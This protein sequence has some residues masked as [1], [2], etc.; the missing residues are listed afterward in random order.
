ME[1]GERETYSHTRNEEED[2]E[3]EDEENMEELEAMLYSQIYYDQSE[4]A[5][6]EFTINNTV[7]DVNDAE[8]EL[9]ESPSAVDSGYEQSRPNS[10]LKEDKD[11]ESD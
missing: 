3:G 10:G 11:I 6:T 9:T 7:R 4:V 5:E 8:K 1:E 2:V